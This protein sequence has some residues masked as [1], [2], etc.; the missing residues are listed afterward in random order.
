MQ[1]KH[2]EIL[3]A[4]FLLIIP[5]IV[6]L[7]QL[8]RFK[9]TPFTN[10]AFLKK[11]AQQTRK[12]SKL[13]KWLILA[14]RLLTMTAFIVAFAQPFLSNS[15]QSKK[16]NTIIYVDN[17]LSMNAKGENGELLKRA[18]QDILKNANLKEPITLLTNHEVYKNLDN[19]NS[20]NTLLNIK[21][22]PLDVSFKH[23]LLKINTLNKN[24]INSS[25]KVV[26]ISDFQE[27]KS[28]NKNDF[29]NVNTA[30]KLIQLTPI[31]KQNFY[32]DS[33]AVVSNISNQIRVQL[34]LK[35]TKP[36]KAKIAISLYNNE[37]LVGKTTANFLNKNV[38]QT[39]FNIPFSKS[40]KG[41]I[42]INDPTLEFDNTFFFTIDKPSKI[43]VLSI[44]KKNNYFSK[45]Y[46]K[47]N[48]TY[49]QFQSNQLDQSQIN[50]QQLIILNEINS[51]SK[52]LMQHLKE[53][54]TNGGNLVII[55]PKTLNIKT[56]QQLFKSF[57]IGSITTSKNKKLKITNIHYQHPI[58]N[59]VFEKQ[60]FNFQYP[61]A[62][63]NTKTVLNKASKIIS[64]DD[65][66][67]FA[68]QQIIGKGKLFWIATSLSE[69]NSNFVN[70]PLIVPLFYKFATSSFQLPKLFYW[71]GKK[72][73][74][75]LH[76]T[77]KKDEVVRLAH[78]NQHFIPLQQT[79]QNSIQ[80]TT[81]ELPVT[82]GYYTIEKDDK[83]LKTI[84]YNY[85]TSESELTYSNLNAL[86]NDTSNV[87]V[88]N[89]IEDTFN[90]LAK[91]K[92]VHAYFKHF[93]VL[94][95]LFLILEMLI[96]KF[97]KS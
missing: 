1:F 53:F 96:L 19:T 32:I 59:D 11:I 44:G 80:I 34:F 2:P 58:F 79:L 82:N 14:T 88:S 89:S 5:I 73:S 70:S 12:S 63:K 47:D 74:I 69:K 68:S 76:S 42:K 56:Y 6:H 24:K 83:V 94:A 66:L 62:I 52:P 95:L 97:Y 9:K 48:F 35:S 7:F 90:S 54:V 57:K 39:F 26:L 67:A 85:D 41:K 21:Y 37:L 8:Q 45:I 84:A 91:E 50:Q 22:D 77:L 55:P 64:F 10:V 28:L 25:N 87:R 65:D 17:S 49:K 43:N 86:F 29:T 38:A 18:I 46:T 75:L 36:T 4:L 30:F 3:Y 60:T 51:I 71:V 16:E 31:N 33:L 13:K 81:E 15:T 40:I 93:L 23:I 72:N 27:I 78:K 92:Q 61:T 20:K